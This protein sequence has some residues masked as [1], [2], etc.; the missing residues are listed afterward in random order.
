[1]NEDLIELGK[2]VGIA[3]PMGLLLGI[4]LR[5][6]FPEWCK[7]WT[8]FCLDKKWKLFLF[9]TLLFSGL[10]AMSF[11][12]G[13]PYFGWFFVGFTL[14]EFWALFAF[15]SKSISEDQ[16]ASIDQSDPTKLR[17]RKFWK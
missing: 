10:A 14:L 6:R 4:V 15:G 13:H 7:S 9:G 11:S 2:I 8:K 1:M 3:A 17:P 16:A 5:K 12:M